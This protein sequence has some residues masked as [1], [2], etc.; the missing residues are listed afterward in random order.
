MFLKIVSNFNLVYSVQ[1]SVNK[2]SEVT[3]VKIEGVNISQVWEENKVMLDDQE[4]LIE[5]WGEELIIAELQV[6]TKF[7][8]AELYNGLSVERKNDR[9]EIKG[10]N[11]FR[12]FLRLFL[13]C[14]FLFA[15]WCLF[16]FFFFWHFC[17]LLRIDSFWCHRDWN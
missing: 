14:W 16:T 17:P 12:A 8:Q 4:M 9:T 5:S 2:D 15:C 1:Q 13:F 11:D 7:G 3:Q 6:P 10:R